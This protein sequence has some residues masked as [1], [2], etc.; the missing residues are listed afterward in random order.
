[1]EEKPD[2]PTALFDDF[3]PYL[4]SGIDLSQSFASK[5]GSIDM[6]SLSRACGFNVK[7][8]TNAMTYLLQI[9]NAV[10]ER[11]NYMVEG[12]YCSNF[13]PIYSKNMYEAICYDGVRGLTAVFACLF[14]ITM[15]GMTMLSLR[16]AFHEV[17]NESNWMEELGLDIEYSD[18]A[19]RDCEGGESQE[20]GS[21]V[22]E[23][24][25][26]AITEIADDGALHEA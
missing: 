3:L 16:V 18:G 10:Q 9:L 22:V 26:E 11:T 20:H 8:T 4:E 15:V 25:E 13:N 6:S 24:I 17:R 21:N 7:S 12:L 5:M 23:I 1:M 14:V 19:E 2:K